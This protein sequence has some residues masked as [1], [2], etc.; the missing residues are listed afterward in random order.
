VEL[1]RQAGLLLD[2]GIIVDEQLHTSAPDVFAA[3]DVA[4]FIHTTLGKRVRVEHEDN[5]LHMGKLAG[6]NMAGANETYTHAPMFYSDLFEH[7]YEAVGE[8][9]SRLETVTDWQEPFHKGTIYYLE[10][11]RVRGVLLWN[12]W[13]Q[14]KNARALLAEAG[15]LQVADLRERLA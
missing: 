5:A 8:I 14:V 6:R 2:N 15:P 13:D 12:I 7:G 9:D 4:N 11:G 1:A 10:N 3:G